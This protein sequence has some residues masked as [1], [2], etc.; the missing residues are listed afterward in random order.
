MFARACADYGTATSGHYKSIVCRGD[1]ADIVLGRGKYYETNDAPGG[2]TVCEAQLTD[3]ERAKDEHSRP[4]VLHD[5]PAVLIYERADVAPA[6][7]TAD[8]T[9]DLL[10]W[11]SD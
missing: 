7:E 9:E 6:V 3:A 8:A 1:A 2:S 11:D 4:V 10:G 5:Q